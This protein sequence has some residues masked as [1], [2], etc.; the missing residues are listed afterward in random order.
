[1][2]RSHVAFGFITT[3]VVSGVLVALPGSSSFAAATDCPT[4]LPTAQAVDGLTGTGYTVEKGTK[5]EEF[6]AKVL[7]RVTD[8]IAPGVDMIMAEVDSPALERAGGVWAGMSGSPVYTSG[9][10]LIGSVS[11]GLAASSKIAGITPAADLLA[12]KGGTKS[13]TKIA[14]S[15]TKAARIASTGEASAKLAAK[16][17]QRLPVPVTITGAAPKNT[18]HF[19]AGIEKNSGPVVR[20]SASAASTLSAS[21]K[22]SP[23]EIF[24][25]SNYAAALSYGD[26]AATALGTTT[27][28]CGKTAIAF[29]HPFFGV[30][31]AEYSVHPATAVY[32][33]A[34][35]VGGPFK[36]G[37]PGG[38]VGTVTQD[39]TIGLTSTLGTAPKHTYPITTSLKNAAGKTF[40][41]K[42]VGV[43]QPYAGDIAA[44]HL[45]SAIVKANGA[46]GA[47]SAAVTYTVTGT[48]AGG[49]KF[50]LTHTDRY[51]DSYD[52]AYAT[53]DALYASISPLVQQ[54][55]ENVNITGVKVTGTVSTTYKPY[56]VTKV[57]T[58][59]SGTWV[60]LK[61]T[62][63]VTS[64][65]TIPLRATLLAYRSTKKVTV[66]LT[67]AVPKKS[68]GWTG[69]LTV[70][71][72]LTA[73]P[74]TNEPASLTALLA[75]L[76]SAPANNVLVSQVDLRS[77]KGAKKHSVRETAL[78]T[79]VSSYFK[80][81]SVTVK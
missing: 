47:G 35:P 29:G 34:D 21:A 45:Q 74:A 40:T 43:Y 10:K 6:T 8:G 18:Q 79:T 33:Q 70:A 38:V 51:A 73:A 76:R 28:V 62:Q 63:K 7:G 64:G 44:T 36:V 57:E 81:V 26:I 27:Y 5:A 42:T 54:E 9:G 24:A 16:G 53:A 52:V 46:Q 75:Q 39:G 58:K 67:V 14:V 25:G 41:G 72:G 61:G 31:P 78:K 69:S 55:F 13:A 59:K 60:A 20:T 80:T 30:G 17:F 65:G 77:S 19:L 37:N 56:R 66:P 22:S 68:K 12:L 48:R 71:D 4:A 23:S 11:Y 1:M 49:K 50:S 3:A 32:V 15:S 2:S